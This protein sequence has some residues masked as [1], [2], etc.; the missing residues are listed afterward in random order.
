MSFK[1][2]CPQQIKR[3]KKFKG[4]SFIMMIF[5][6]CYHLWHLVIHEQLETDYQVAKQEVQ[7]EAVG[8][9]VLIVLMWKN[10]YAYG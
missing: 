8:R 6:K 7:C 4:F 1:G 3:P 9:I 2:T 10:W 5:L